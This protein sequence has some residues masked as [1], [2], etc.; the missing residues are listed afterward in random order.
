MIKQADE[1]KWNI[2]WLFTQTPRPS[3]ADKLKYHLSI[4]ANIRID[5]FNVCQPNG[6][7]DMFLSQFKPLV[8]E[9]SNPSIWKHKPVIPALE[10]RR[11]EFKATLNSLGSSKKGPYTKAERVDKGRLSPTG[12]YLASLKMIIMYTI[13]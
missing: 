9:K 2:G 1:T 7:K 10:S 5:N 6:Y 8:L 11:Q 13:S 4:S 3:K 12:E